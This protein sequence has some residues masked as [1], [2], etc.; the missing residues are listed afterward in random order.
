MPG[1][2]KDPLP[3]GVQLLEEELQEEVL[4]EVRVPGGEVQAPATGMGGGEWIGR[5]GMGRTGGGGAGVRDSLLDRAW[6]R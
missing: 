5:G 6:N 2:G 3:G 4:L 1:R